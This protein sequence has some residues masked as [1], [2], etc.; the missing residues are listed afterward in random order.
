MKPPKNPGLPFNFDT[1]PLWLKPDLWDESSSVRFRGLFFVV[2][3]TISMGAFDAI[4][5]IP[6]WI[7]KGAEAG[8]VTIAVWFCLTIVA[9]VPI[10]LGC[11]WDFIR[12]CRKLQAERC[13][14]PLNESTEK[15]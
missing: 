13:D 15:D 6:V 1:I 11:W 3:Y 10:G 5:L 7:Y 2:L 12:E 8:G 14:A 4:I 9:G